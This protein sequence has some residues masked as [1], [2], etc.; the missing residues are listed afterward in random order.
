VARTRRPR[1]DR[2]GPEAVGCSHAASPALVE[3]EQRVEGHGDRHA[4]RVAHGLVEVE[5]PAAQQA[6]QALEPLGHRD[7]GRAHVA[8]VQRRGTRSRPPSACPRTPGRSAASRCSSGAARSVGGQRRRAVEQ[9]LASSW[10]LRS[11][12]PAAAEARVLQQA[13][14]E[15]LGGLRGRELVELL[16]LLAGQHQPRLELQQRRDE[17]EELRRGLEVELLARLE[18]VT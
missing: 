14:D 11:Q 7:R 18:V 17:H 16:D 6:A 12:L 9:A 2:D 13:L 3:L 5:A 10:A 15:L 4:I 1:G 8:Q